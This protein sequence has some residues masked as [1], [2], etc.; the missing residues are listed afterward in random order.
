MTWSG[1]FDILYALPDIEFD[2]SQGLHSIPAALGVPR[3]IVVA[4]AL[5][6]VTAAALAATVWVVGAGV[7]AWIGV[8]VAAAILAYE[9]SL[10]S[11]EDLSKLDAA[12]F[13]MNGVISL[14]FFAFVLADLVVGA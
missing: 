8:A 10:V 1:G 11:A 9:H 7:L 5:H 2:R 13:T 14:T 6:L 12:F 3:A 4:R